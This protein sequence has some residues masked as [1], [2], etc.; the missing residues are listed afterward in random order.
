MLGTT[1]LK[2]FNVASSYSNPSANANANPFAK[3][4]SCIEL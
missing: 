1:F 2:S 3:L 4:A